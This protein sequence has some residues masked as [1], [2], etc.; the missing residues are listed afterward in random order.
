MS[1][2]INFPYLFEHVCQA[3]QFGKSMKIGTKHR[4]LEKAQSFGKSARFSGTR[5]ILEK[6]TFCC[7]G[8]AL[9]IANFSAQIGSVTYKHMLFCSNIL[10]LCELELLQDQE[11]FNFAN[12]R[13]ELPE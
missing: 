3:A 11:V 6:R 5:T 9:K 12:R 1:F 8:I 2:V 13:L 10:N 4:V 7:K